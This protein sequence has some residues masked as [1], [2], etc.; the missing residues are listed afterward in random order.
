[1]VVLI[2]GRQD[3]GEFVDEGK[4]T[5]AASK[6]TR[7]SVQN[8]MQTQGL[9][10][11]IRVA[12]SNPAVPRA[13]AAAPASPPESGWP[14]RPPQPAFVCVRGDGEGGACDVPACDVPAVVHLLANHV[15]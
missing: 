3:R 8:H 13:P 9:D 14:W 1:M 5:K 15:C 2:A 12:I 4:Y 10:P 7:Q 11:P 6:H